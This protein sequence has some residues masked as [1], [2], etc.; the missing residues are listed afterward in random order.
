MAAA[1]VA[2]AAAL[3]LQANPTFTPAQVA[4]A[5]LRGARRG[6]VTDDRHTPNRLLYVSPAG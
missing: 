3:V 2:G 6:V 5:I 1:H 4:S